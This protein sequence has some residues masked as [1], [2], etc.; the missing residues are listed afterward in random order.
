M[1]KLDAA[2][3]EVA[4]WRATC[5]ICHA[6]IIGSKAMLQAHAEACKRDH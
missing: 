1:E 6:N 2:M 4:D 3:E 5:H